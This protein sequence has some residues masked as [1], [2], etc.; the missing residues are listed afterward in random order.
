MST[1]GKALMERD[2]KRE[3]ENSARGSMSETTLGAALRQRDALK[4]AEE[5]KK[6]KKQIEEAE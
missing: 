1:L 5:E 4:K 2:R 6:E 3:Q